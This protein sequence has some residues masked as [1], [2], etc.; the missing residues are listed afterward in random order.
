MSHGEFI[1]AEESN[2]GEI[3]VRLITNFQDG[4]KILEISQLKNKQFASF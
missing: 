1:T 2:S 3:R 4:K